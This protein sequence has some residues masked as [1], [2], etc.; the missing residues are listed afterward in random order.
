[1]RKDL[2]KVPAVF[3]MPVLMVAAY[4]AAG[5]VQVMNAAWGMI[6]DMDKIALFIDEEHATTK[7]IRQTGAFTVSIADRDHMDVA[8]YYGIA[9]GNRMPDKFLRSGYHEEKSKHVNA[10]IITEFPLA[11][12]CELAEITETENL[13][14][15][16]G[17]IVNVSAEESVL[18]ENGK[19]N[20][21]KL[22]ALIF[23]QFQ[24]GYYV[25]TEKVGKAWNA[26]KEIMKAARG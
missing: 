24:P 5:T 7:A 15:V 20:P 25:A 3:P 13:H 14:A 23:D 9:T 8:D 21:M 10:P 18:D 2:G 17:R 11:M 22:N 1:M 4:D 6:S 16:V 19:V 12:E 26:G